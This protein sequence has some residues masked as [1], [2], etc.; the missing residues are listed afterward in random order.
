MKNM[1]KRCIGWVLLPAVLLTITICI[2]ADATKAGPVSWAG[3]VPG[4]ELP[5]GVTSVADNERF[6]LAIKREKAVSGEGENASASTLYSVEITAKDSGVTYSTLVPLDYYG[7]NEKSKVL[8]DGLSKMFSVSITDFGSRSEVLHSSAANTVFHYDTISNGVR[9]Y[10]YFPNRDVGLTAY[11]TIDEDGLSVRVPEDGLVEGGKY[12]ILSL[13]V[14][15][16]FGAIRSGDDGYILFPDGSGAIYEIPEK[17][18]SQ[19]LTTVDVYSPT[20]M[21]LETLQSN[22]L[23]GVKNVMLPI[24]GI[25]NGDSALFGVLTEGETYA[26]LNLAPGGHIYGELNRIYPTFRY[27]KSFEFQTTNGMEAYTIEKERRVGDVGVRYFFLSGENADYSGMARTYR[28]WL[29]KEG[30]LRQ[31]DIE[32]PVVN[33]TF[34]GGIT[35]DSLFGNSLEV[36]SKFDDIAGVMEKQIEQ[37]RDGFLLTVAGWQKSGYGVYP[38]HLPVASALGGKNG[39]MQLT[40]LLKSKGIPLL[41]SDN[42]LMANEHGSRPDSQIIYDYMNLPVSDG[43]DKN[44]LLNPLRTRK[45]ISKVLQMC[46]DTDAGLLFEKYGSLLYED[47]SSKGGI[48]RTE[49]ADTL[50][51]TLTQAKQQTGIAAAS[52][53]NAY[54]LNTADW[55]ADIPIKASGYLIFNYEVPFYQMVVHGSIPYAPVLPGNMSTDFQREKLYWLETGSTPYFLLSVNPDDRLKYTIYQEPFSLHYEDWEETINSVYDEFAVL[56]AYCSG[57]M[58]KHEILS[59]SLRRVTYENGCV[60]L[61]NFADTEQTVDGCTMSPQGYV[62]LDGKGKT[63]CRG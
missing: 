31:S 36:L 26:Q 25:K 22:R 44:Y 42:F 59:E 37:G 60:L 58:H 19:K 55:L 28:Q 17:A 43:T 2:A 14:L 56:S 9:L 45:E 54:L 39:L 57:A 1:I 34:L 10:V 29:L 50:A 5:E 46:Q 20:D 62:L 24:L 32:S 52:G 7:S 61:L 3:G 63:L 48:T 18:T 35:A 30:K 49:M 41:L 15:P 27:R 4:T 6:S 13:D 33:A 8:R 16:M 53:G 47:Y 11:F 40:A 21:K 38:A 12:G 51:E 23:Q